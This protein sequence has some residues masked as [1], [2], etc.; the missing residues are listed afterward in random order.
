[1]IYLFYIILVVGIVA[2]T[3]W[4]FTDTDKKKRQQRRE[5]EQ[6]NCNNTHIDYTNTSDEDYKKLMLEKADGNNINLIELQTQLDEQKKMLEDIKSNVGCITFIMIFPIALAI[7][8][9]IIRVIFSV[10]LIEY[11]FS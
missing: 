11:F 5:A 7:L 6:F 2:P 8:I 1:M 10:N 9:F 3:I 4:A